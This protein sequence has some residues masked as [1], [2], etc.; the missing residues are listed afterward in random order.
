LPADAVPIYGV[1][2]LLALAGLGLWIMT[3][4]RPS[5]GTPADVIIVCGRAAILA[6]SVTFIVSPHY[7]WYF[8]WLALPAVVQPYWSVIWLSA[9]PVLLYHD[10]FDDPFFWRSVIYVPAAILVLIDLFRAR[11]PLSQM[12]PSPLKGTP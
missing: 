6:T 10:P 4:P 2:A 7:A 12:I 9:A 1:V 11:N 5:P 8:A 3:R